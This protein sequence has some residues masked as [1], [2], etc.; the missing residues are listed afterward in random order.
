MTFF[1]QTLKKSTKKLNC[2]LS[3][4]LYKKTSTRGYN[5]ASQIFQ[6]LRKE[7]VKERLWKKDCE[8]KIVKERLWKRD[9]ERE[10]V[11][12]RLW[13]K[14]YERKIVKEILWERF[15]KK[16]LKE[17]FERRIVKER[18]WEI[19]KDRLRVEDWKR[20][21]VEMWK[22]IFDHFPPFL[23]YQKKRITDQQTDG[24]TK[25]PTDGRTYPLIEMHGRI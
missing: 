24:P 20:K 6:R 18:L 12:E 5:D 17:D 4:F 1:I 19:L 14:D 25:G 16:I 13:R 7:I 22:V 8:R 9:W 21:P 2:S 15:E 23:P 10:I 3:I 11:K